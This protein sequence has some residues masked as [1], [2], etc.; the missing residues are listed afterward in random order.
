MEA[1][2]YLHRAAKDPLPEECDIKITASTLDDRER[3]TFCSL[4]DGMHWNDRAVKMHTITPRIDDA[5]CDA[6]GSKSTVATTLRRHR[7]GSP[8][9]LV[10]NPSPPD[11]PTPG[12]PTRQRVK[13]SLRHVLLVL[14]TCAVL[15]S[16]RAQTPELVDNAAPPALSVLVDAFRAGDTD[17]LMKH[18]AH[19]L[20]L[21]LFGIS[22]LFSRSQAGYVLSD[23]FN[24][25][26]PLRL[27]MTETSGSE[28]NWFAAGRYWYQRGEAPLTVYFRLRSGDGA[29]E[30]REVRIG[31]T[32]DR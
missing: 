2:L 8:D 7:A 11:A 4:P 3:I 15:P 23:F 9:R 25:Y 29:W 13:T 20:D 6:Q 16:A 17:T 24:E 27:Q 18:S 12:T 30:L 1:R 28:G 5:R 32:A 21:T 31:R 22:E 26:R 14:L 19:R 10:E